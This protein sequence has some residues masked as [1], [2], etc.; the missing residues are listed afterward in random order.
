MRHE[1]DL[2]SYAGPHPPGVVVPPQPPGWH[3][4]LL[5][6]TGAMTVEVPEGNWFVPPGS[7]V[8]VP[9]D[10]TH[11]IRTRST[12]RLR[13]LY[14]RGRPL[15]PTRVVEMTGLLEALVLAAV[16]R[17]PL[18]ADAGVRDAAL[19][20]LVEAEVAAARAVEPLRLALPSDPAAR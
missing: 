11:R 14:L 10:V 13:N 5:A 4:V 12:T 20:A 7:G 3:Q 6:T 2:R 18:W 17:A 16:E 15:G 8:V 1:P 19:I 9:A